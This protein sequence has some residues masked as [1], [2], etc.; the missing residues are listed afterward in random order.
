MRKQG[1]LWCSSFMK[2][3]GAYSAPSLAI[4]EAALGETQLSAGC[5]PDR[6]NKTEN[7]IQA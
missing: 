6:K 4:G 3:L 7:P 2:E 5:S 1:A